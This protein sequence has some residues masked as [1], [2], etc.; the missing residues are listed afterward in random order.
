MDIIEYIH[1]GQKNIKRV[2]DCMYIISY[3]I[4][5]FLSNRSHTYN[6]FVEVNPAF[7]N[8]LL[9]IEKM[10]LEHTFLFVFPF[11]GAILITVP[12]WCEWEMPPTGQW[13]WTIGPSLGCCFR[14][15][16]VLGR[17]GLVDKTDHWSWALGFNT[18]PHVLSTLSLLIVDT[19][20]S[21]TSCFWCMDSLTQWVIPISTGGCWSEIHSWHYLHMLPAHA[22]IAH[23]FWI[24]PILHRMLDAM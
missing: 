8:S 20:W 6:I 11:L 17:G 13:A 22:Q 15:L 23:L 21:A 9:V 12:V 18:L 14:K 5:I 4:L 10:F 2:I 1:F 24:I 3:T 16:H 19:I 7:L